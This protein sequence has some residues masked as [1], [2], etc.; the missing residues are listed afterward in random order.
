MEEL[1]D[2][3]RRRGLQLNLEVRNVWY[4]DAG[5]I[6]A[7]ARLRDAFD[8]EATM[9]PKKILPA[10]ARCFDFGRTIPEGAWL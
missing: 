9:N 10:G 8:P 1:Y 2:S 3:V 6:D 7:Q 5:Y 4:D